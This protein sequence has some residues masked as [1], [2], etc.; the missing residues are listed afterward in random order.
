LASGRPRGV[1]LPGGGG[2]R[3]A[4]GSRLGTE[5]A[6]LLA[7]TTIV[8]FDGID[9][10]GVTIA[11]LHRAGATVDRVAR[12]LAASRARWLPVLVDGLALGATARECVTI[13]RGDWST[14]RVVHTLRDTAA[15]LTLDGA[16]RVAEGGAAA[17]FPG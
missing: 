14:A 16:R 10:R 13:M 15:R 5:R 8:N 9:D 6:H 4:G 1:V 17:V 3:L 2:V 7:D 11:L 12:T